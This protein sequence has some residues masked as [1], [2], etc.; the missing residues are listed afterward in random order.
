[1]GIKVNKICS[2]LPNNL[3]TN[4]DIVEFMPTWTPDKIVQK[5]GIEKRYV[6]DKDQTALDLAIE[7]C[8]KIKPYV[9]F[10]SI[11]GLVLCTQSPDYF[12]PTTSCILQDKI[13]LK[14]STA[15]FDFNLGCSGYIY[16]LGI[17]KGLIT[18]GIVK[19]V[20]FVTSE[21]YSKYLDFND[22]SNR[23]LFGDGATVSF[24]S[25]TENESVLEFSLGTDGSGFNNLIVENGGARNLNSNL[26]ST[27]FMNGPKIFDFTNNII[28]KLVTKTLFVNNLK[29]D[30]I[31]FFVFHQ[32]NKFIL[33]H[34]RSKLNIPHEKFLMN[35][36]NSGNTV[37]STIPIVLEK[38]I[39]DNSFR[40][41]IVMLIGFGVGYSWGGTI[42][43]L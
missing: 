22:G 17:V 25:Y 15:C 5:I 21:T 20:L 30:Q 16:G 37:S 1:M 2:F 39:E 40:N 43:K 12:L 29:L 18:S 41:K 31:D 3:I 36:E 23:A 19:N 10:D 11:D 28:P 4:N 14:T 6:V 9:D 27:F 33:E 32:A 35:M 38:L 8:G 42:M 24:I 13:G 34:L 26:K 7:V